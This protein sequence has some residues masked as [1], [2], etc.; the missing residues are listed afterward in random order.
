M[1]IKV[2]NIRDII[3]KS[4]RIGFSLSNLGYHYCLLYG[5]IL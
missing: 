5:V 1:T 3:I 4:D 2:I